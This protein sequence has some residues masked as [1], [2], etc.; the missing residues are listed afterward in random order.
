MKNWLKAFGIVCLMGGISS[1]IGATIFL[2]TPWF[3]AIW[4]I[5][6]LIILTA[7]TKLILFDL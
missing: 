4:I 6:T 2:P 5:I 1:S 7:M 3:E